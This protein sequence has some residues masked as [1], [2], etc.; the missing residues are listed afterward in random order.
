MAFPRQAAGSKHWQEFLSVPGQAY[1]EVQA[2]LA[3]TQTEHLP[4]PAGA[5]WS[6][7]EAY[8]LLEVEP[9]AVHGPDWAAACEAVENGIEA[10]SGGSF[11]SPSSGASSRWRRSTGSKYG[12]IAAGVAGPCSKT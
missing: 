12:F 9:A 11:T 4:M 2:G 7:L 3:R 1:I 6:W 10:L 5:E 8:G